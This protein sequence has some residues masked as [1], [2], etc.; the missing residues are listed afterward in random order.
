MKNAPRDSPVGLLTLQ[1]CIHCAR[2]FASSLSKICNKEVMVYTLSPSLALGQIDTPSVQRLFDSSSIS[3]LD[4]PKTT[5]GFQI[6][7]ENQGFLSWNTKIGHRYWVEMSPDLVNWETLEGAEFTVREAQG[8]PAGVEIGGISQHN[9]YFFRVAETIAAQLD[10]SFALSEQDFRDFMGAF[11]VHLSVQEQQEVLTG[12]FSVEE[13][14]ELQLS[15]A[16]KEAQT[17]AAI[18]L[19]P[20]QILGDR[21]RHEASAQQANRSISDTAAVRALAVWFPGKGYGPD[22]LHYLNTDPMRNTYDIEIQK[23]GGFRQEHDDDYWRDEEQRRRNDLLDEL[24]QYKVSRIIYNFRSALAVDQEVDKHTPLEQLV[25]VLA[26]S[27]QA[28]QEA[29]QEF[30]TLADS[31]IEKESELYQFTR[32][33]ISWEEIPEL[34]SEQVLLARNNIRKFD[35]H[36]TIFEAYKNGTYYSGGF[37][38]LNGAGHALAGHLL[39]QKAEQKEA[40]LEEIDQGIQTLNT[41]LPLLVEELLTAKQV[42]FDYPDGFLEWSQQIRQHYLQQQSPLWATWIGVL[43]RTDA[44][45][46]VALKG[47]QDISG[48]SN[49]IFHFVNFELPQAADDFRFKINHRR[50]QYEAT[51]EI[52]PLRDKIRAFADFLGEEGI[53]IHSSLQTVQDSLS[54]QKERRM[55]WDADIERIANYANSLT[56]LQDWEDYLYNDLLRRNPGASQNTIRSAH[57]TFHDQQTRLIRQARDSFN[58]EQLDQYWTSLTSNRTPYR[59]DIAQTLSRLIYAAHDSMVAA[60]ANMATAE[61]FSANPMVVQRDQKHAQ[62]QLN[63]LRDSAQLYASSVEES[64]DSLSDYQS[65]HQDWLWNLHQWALSDPQTSGPGP[66]FTLEPL[67]A[68]LQDLETK[69]NDVLFLAFMKAQTHK[70]L[71]KPDLYLSPVVD[72]ERRLNTLRYFASPQGRQVTLYQRHLDSELMYEPDGYFYEKYKDDDRFFND[73][74]EISRWMIARA[75]SGFYPSLEQPEPE[76]FEDFT[77]GS[78]EEVSEEEQDQRDQDTAFGVN[79]VALDNENKDATGGIFVGSEFEFYHSASKPAAENY[80][81]NLRPQ[82][83]PSP[84]SLNLIH[85]FPEKVKILIRESLFTWNYHGQWMVNAEGI[86][87][88]DYRRW[89]LKYTSLSEPQYYAD[90]MRF[91]QNKNSQQISLAITANFKRDFAIAFLKEWG[92]SADSFGQGLTFGLTN[93]EFAVEWSENIASLPNEILDVLGVVSLDLERLKNGEI[94]GNEFALRVS[95][96][97]AKILS[98]SISSVIPPTS[99]DE[100][101]TQILEDTISKIAE[102]QPGRN[103]L[104]RLIRQ[105]DDIDRFLTEVEHSNERSFKNITAALTLA[106]VLVDLKS[107]NQS[108]TKT[109]RN[110]LRDWIGLVVLSVRNNKDSILKLSRKLSDGPASVNNIYELVWRSEGFTVNESSIGH[111]KIRHLNRT[112]DSLAQE[113]ILK[114][115]R[116]QRT[117]PPITAFTDEA[118][119]NLALEEWFNSPQSSPYIEA[120]KELSSR[121][122]TNRE[123]AEAVGLVLPSPSTV[124]ISS[125]DDFGMGFSATSTQK[126]ENVTSLIDKVTVILSPDGKGGWFLLTA[127][128]SL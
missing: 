64:L 19:I 125:V 61:G 25:P 58:Q 20:D 113:A 60:Y 11:H 81:V 14:P 53:L 108:Y 57:H 38:K 73:A 52:V 79:L 59:D 29:Q 27:E 16:D 33:K 118:K 86:P 128:P 117:T 32:Q 102:T 123:S 88:N 83:G 87:F 104:D 126:L 76:G 89:K 84:E 35:Y 112:S 96:A 114:A 7:S 15:I 50:E 67:G 94:N 71:P 99:L 85:Q 98:S 119:M 78:E 46:P 56:Y 74:G 30:E 92:D 1:Q 37:Y 116:E 51:R 49:Q 34:D 6:L 3:E 68:F 5:Q 2:L 70:T 107:G 31:W 55:P 45:Y 39:V 17:Q 69:I 66:D 44:D 26:L 12:T 63:I 54:D 13:N 41:A 47:F 4:E 62:D 40:K 9:Q 48:R 101:A 110:H 21:L 8:I 115:K 100:H 109:G 106:A 111:T 75:Q 90:Y 80:E 82:I 77:V 65:G 103:A 97:S 105:I 36:G 24:E 72:L 120:I 10:S 23:M 91:V 127:Y 43:P 28:I 22:K 121:G 124:L 93:G 18:S 95:A 122:I 42:F